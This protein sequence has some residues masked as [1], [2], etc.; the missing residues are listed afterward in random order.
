MKS[1]IEKI[2]EAFEEGRTV[3]DFGTQG[4]DDALLKYLLAKEGI[5]IVTSLSLS[6]SL[7]YLGRN[8]L[9]P[10]SIFMM[11]ERQWASLTHLYLSTFDFIQIKILLETRDANTFRWS[12]SLNYK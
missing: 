5:K 2:D 4:I 7:R 1:I 8:P 3:I 12:A 9:S 6:T 11:R 10:L